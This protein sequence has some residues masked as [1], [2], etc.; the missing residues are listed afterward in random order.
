MSNTI[1]GK[2]IKCQ[3]MELT[4]RKQAWTLSLYRLQGRDSEERKKNMMC[5]SFHCWKHGI[6][7]ISRGEQRRGKTN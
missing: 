1:S 5:N 3:G 2:P 7:E 4:V 6:K